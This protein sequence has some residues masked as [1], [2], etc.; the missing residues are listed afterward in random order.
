MTLSALTVVFPIIGIVL[1]IFLSFAIWSSRY[2]K[3]G[4]NQ[5]LVISGRQ[6][7]FQNPD[8]TVSRRGY[9]LVKGGGSFVLPVIEKVDVL[10]LEPVTV[11]F[12]FEKSISGVAQVKINSDD[13]SLPKAAEHF[14]NKGA[15]GIRETA[16]QI[17]ESHWRKTGS[18]KIEE[19]VARDLATMGL[20]L[21][22]FSIR[23]F[24]ETNVLISGTAKPPLS[25][26][27]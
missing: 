24:N 7:L 15:D 26:T 13:A 3:V 22:S 12:R 19:Q 1:V 16:V 9:R 20:S 14:L 23:S 5:V 2:T 17:I 8:G 10:S 18:Q 4:P 6:Y 11:E 25:A 21:L 27:T